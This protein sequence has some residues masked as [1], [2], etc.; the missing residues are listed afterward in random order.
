MLL[1]GQCIAGQMAFKDG[2]MS[3]YWRPYLVMGVDAARREVSILNISSTDGKEHKLLFPTNVP[4]LNSMP[5]LAKPSFVKADSLQVISFDNARD[6]DL[7]SGGALISPTDLKAV[8]DA[9]KK[10]DDS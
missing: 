5:P 8:L 4:L 10:L 1:V 2:T 3:A 7:L 9:F 6:F